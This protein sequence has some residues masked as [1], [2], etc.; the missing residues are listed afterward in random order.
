[1]FFI[2]INNIVN[3]CWNMEFVIYCII[4]IVMKIYYTLSNLLKLLLNFFFK[5][6]LFKK[7]ILINYFCIEFIYIFLKKYLSLL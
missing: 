2:C 4:N 6:I 5:I 3:E 7:F 1:M